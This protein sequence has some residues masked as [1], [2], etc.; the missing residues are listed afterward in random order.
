MQEYTRIKK[1]KD[2]HRLPLEGNIDLT[3]RCNLNCRHCWLWVP[4]NSPE[5][6][7]ELTL[8]EI[9]T[10]VDEARKMGCR[11]WYISGGEPM[12]RPDFAEIFDY[13]T[14]QSG[15]YTLNTNGTLIT[16][17]I[18]R[19]MRRRGTKMVSLC[20]ATAETYDHVTRRPGGFD[21]AMQGF[22]YLKEAGTG[23]MVQLI[24]MRDNW[25][26]WEKMMKLAES[27]SRHWR[28]G[29]PRL[30]LSSCHDPERNAEITRQRLDPR[31]VVALDKPGLCD[32]EAAAHECGHREGDDR[33]FARCIPHRQM[34][35]VDP[36]GGM[37]FC[38]YIKDPAL[39]YDL[40]G[41]TFR[42]AWE[43]FIPSLADRVRGGP[44][45]DRNCAACDK[46]KDCRWC[47]VYGW[48][49][50]GRFSAPVK[51][52]CDVAVEV[53]RFKGESQ[54]HHRCY[55]RIGGITIQVDSDLPIDDRTF[56]PTLTA[57][58][59]EGPGE[60]TVTIHHHFALPDLTGKDLG[61]E[62]YRKPPWAI[63]RR[64]GSYM[65]LGI[66]PQTDDPSLHRVATF[67]ADHS[68]AHIYNDREDT[69]LK[70]DLH[71][72][73]LFP[74]DQILIARLLADRRG[75]CLHSAGAILG[76]AG[77]LFVGHS[78][79]G[80]STIAR[81]LIQDGHS[82]RSEES[83]AVNAESLRTAPGNRG[84]AEILCDDRNIVRCLDGGWRVYGTWSHGDV[85]VVSANDAP[86]RAVC[87][88]EQA[89][90]NTLTPLTDSREIIRRLLACVIKP[91]VTA[92]W[93]HKTFDTAEQMAKEVPFY[94]MRFDQS[95]KI[96]G[97][98]RRL[99]DT[100]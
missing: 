2:L 20:G 59:V 62:L 84:A 11:H 26:E 42:E 64:N 65:Y 85:Q 21:K 49:E 53:Q 83:F 89:S 94:V 31:D 77:M 34:F 50:H 39:R 41:G 54:A 27:L 93:W 35:N 40:R 28:V 10:I 36:Y 6:E 66:S 56:H 33:L 46:R 63:S 78:E 15:S 14:R 12:L 5:R 99:I 71:S 82:A 23:F 69:W 90:A 75:C 96:V 30:H 25:H 8:E 81:L 67:N 100:G 74:S 80:K 13:T 47:P 73:T 45:Y 98:L 9:K 61:R 72:L 17:E 37:T 70:G 51:H 43:S 18:A 44:E 55:F 38:A 97:E 86:L 58:R 57:F 16:P 24:P 1:V 88:I 95:G 32:E 4:E 3:Y 60:D 79:T 7:N 68:R 92:D 48:L 22:R 29:T 76:G 87:F 91:F 52:L 19:L